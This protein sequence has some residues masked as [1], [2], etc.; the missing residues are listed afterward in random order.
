MDWEQ[1]PWYTIDDD[2]DKD[3]G[4][5]EWHGHNVFFRDEND[6]IFRTHCINNRGDEA[7]GSV[8]SYLD[9][10]PQWRQEDWERLAARIPKDPSLHLVALARRISKCRPQVVDRMRD[11]SCEAKC[12]DGA[13]K[14]SLPKLG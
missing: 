11:P 6:Q 12:V 10:T 13:R 2:F 8:W 4:A 7:I 3:F 9:L 1:I 14:I 5:D